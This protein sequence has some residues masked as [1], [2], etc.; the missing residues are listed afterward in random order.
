ME[1]EKEGEGRD[2]G[3]GG[4]VDDGQGETLTLRHAW[5]AHAQCVS[6]VSLLAED[7]AVTSSYDHS[8]KLWSLE[9]QD[10]LVSANSGKVRAPKHP[11]PSMPSMPS[12]PL[13]Y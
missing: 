12:M 4:D 13:E 10:C 3:S 11:M 1:A 5:K 6:G 8:V 9:S 7:R 2:R